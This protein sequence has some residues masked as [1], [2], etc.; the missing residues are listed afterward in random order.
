MDG[1]YELL[2]YMTGQDIYTHQLGAAADAATPALKAQYPF[3]SELQPPTGS[4]PADLMAW[5]VSVEREHGEALTVTPLKDWEHRDPIEDA[6]D[7]VGADKVF[8]V[9]F[10]D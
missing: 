9:P 4:D 5:L 6:C 7:T 2:A 3:L 8:V 10:G 1:L